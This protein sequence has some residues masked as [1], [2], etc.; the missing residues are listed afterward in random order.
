MFTQIRPGLN[1][2]L[3]PVG[4]K[5]AGLGITA[6]QVSLVGTLGVVGGALGFYPRGRFLWGTVFITCFVF[7][8]TL[9]GAVARA[10]GTSGKWG[11]FLDSTLD[12]MGDAAIFGSL[13]LWFAGGGHS[14]VMAGVAI[15]DLAAAQLTSYVKARAEGLGMRCDVGLVERPERLLAIL[16]AT[17]FTG[18][19]GVPALQVWVL[20]ALAGAMTATVVQRVVVVRRE[21]NRAAATVP[22]GQP[23]EA[24]V[25]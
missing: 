3:T 10:R 14:F 25:R 15:Y 1:R 12:R 9:D 4:R 8:D 24:V 23:N 7:G 20:W 22:E 18:I 19:L 21:A 2:A 13:A 6:D 5:L 11:S 17:G 16:I